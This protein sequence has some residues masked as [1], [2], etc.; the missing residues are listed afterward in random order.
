MS[1]FEVLIECLPFL[2]FVGFG[3]YLLLTALFPSWREK[4]W[5]HWKFY[6]IQ[7]G[8]FTQST[9]L[10]SLLQ[11]LGFAK[12]RKPV[13]EGDFDDKTALLLYYILGAIFLILGIGGLALIVYHNI[14]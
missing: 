8:N 14:T 7:Y 13:S 10:N 6:G 12:Q 2:A 5:K 11:G 3:L 9:Y 1:T 4:N